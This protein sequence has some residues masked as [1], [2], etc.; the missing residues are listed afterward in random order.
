MNKARQLWVGFE[1]VHAVTYFAPE[2]IEANREVGLKGF[3][4]GYFAS[5]SAP[6]G[7]PSAAEV[8]ET[9]FVFRP[10]MVERAIPDAW[11]FATQQ[12]VL[13]TRVQV[14][15]QVLRSLGDEVKDSAQSIIEPIERVTSDPHIDGPLSGPNR[16]LPNRA[17]PV[18]RLWQACTTLREHRGDAHFAAL[19]AAGLGPVDTVVLINASGGSSRERL[20][21]ARGWTDNEWDES[22]E[23]LRERALLGPEGNI[24]SE[25]ERIRAELEDITDQRAIEPWAAVSKAERDMVGTVLRSLASSIADAGILTYPNPIGLPRP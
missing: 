20:Q 2:C 15:A 10:S 24:T 8:V 19:R 12:A 3:W 23:S 7:T 5:R 1:T 9:F 17:D 22:F 18:E 14:A 25:G 16:D 4:M 13:E 21:A 6:L 11:S